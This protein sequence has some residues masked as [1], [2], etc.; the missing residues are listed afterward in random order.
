[1]TQKLTIRTMAVVCAVP[2]P[3]LTLAEPN[4]RVAFP[5][6]K[7]KRMKVA[8]VPFDPRISNGARFA[9][10]REA[11]MF[12]ARHCEFHHHTFNRRLARMYLPFCRTLSLVCGAYVSCAGVSK[13][14]FDDVLRDVAKLFESR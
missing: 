10:L 5:V 13:K 12:V 6:Q 1:M 3:D 8:P 4:L 14:E 9:N 2:L 11:L 7:Y